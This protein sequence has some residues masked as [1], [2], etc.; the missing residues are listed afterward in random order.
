MAAERKSDDVR[1]LEIE[2]EGWNWEVLKM[3]PKSWYYQY[4]KANQGRE[5]EESTL[6]VAMNGI[7][8]A[9]ASD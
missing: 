3:R 6:A 1:R 2:V 7:F 9:F 8:L 4:K 5:V